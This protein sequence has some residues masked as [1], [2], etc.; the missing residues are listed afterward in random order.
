MTGHGKLEINAVDYGNLILVLQAQIGSRHLAVEGLELV[1]IRIL[2]A[3][4]H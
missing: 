4:V 3:F 1:G 2:L